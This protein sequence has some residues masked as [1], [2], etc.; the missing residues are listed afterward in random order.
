[1]HSSLVNEIL[2]VVLAAFVGGYIARTLKL[3][4]VVGYIVGGVVFGF[5]GKQFLPSFENILHLSEFGVALFLFTLGFEISLDALKKVNRKV[6]TAALLQMLITPIVL[7]GVLQLFRLDLMTAIFFSLVFSFSSMAVIGK[8]LEEKGQLANFPGNAVFLMLLFK[9]ALVIPT[10]FILPFILSKGNGIESDTSTILLG[11]GKSLAI[12]VLIFFFAKYFLSTVLRL[13][14]RY[15][16]QELTLLATIF[17]AT[18]SI[19]LLTWAGLPIAI[20]AFFAGLILSQHGSN[21]EPAAAI[22]PFKDILLALFF[23]VTGM[24]IDPRFVVEEFPLIISLTGLVL[25]TKIIV[26]SIILRFLKFTPISNVFITSHLANVGEFAAI[27]AQ[28]AFIQNFIEGSTYELILSV[29]VISLLLIPLL[30]KIASYMFDKSKR[31]SFFKYL[32]GNAYTFRN[33]QFEGVENH[34]VI[35]GHGRVG[36]EVR[37]ILDMG[38]VPYVVVDFNKKA[39]DEL[40]RDSKNAL[41]GDPSDDEVL[42]SAGIEKARILVVAI[43]EGFTQKVLI[44]NAL[45]LNPKIVVLCRSHKDDDKYELVNLGVNTIV[46]PEFEAGLRIGRKVL[47]LLGVKEKDADDMLSRIRKFH[48]VS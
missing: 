3:S 17:I 27:I 29:F 41:Y 31:M 33:V 35:C 26:S 23:V 7:F 15:P 10:V 12:F 36:R 2:L 5:F 47:E 20:A 30:L 43:P 38:E 34:I 42:K 25:F 9:D 32:F 11:V 44:K 19:G 18:I 40:L 45:K 37:K 4:P 21:L 48:L 24:L 14:F 22:R 46:M 1:M 39:V 8:L 6:L 28:I 13:I 16:S